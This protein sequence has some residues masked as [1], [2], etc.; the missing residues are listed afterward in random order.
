MCAHSCKKKISNIHSGGL[1]TYV[2]G[3]VKKDPQRFPRAYLRDAEGVCRVADVLSIFYSEAQKADAKAFSTLMQHIKEIDEDKFTVVMVQVENEVGLLG[4]SRDRGIAANGRFESPVPREVLD[5]LSHQNWDYLNGSI[6]KNLEV[7]YSSTSADN[8]SWDS[9]FGSG[10]HAD[11]IFMAYHYALYLEKVASAGKSSY[12]IP[13]YTNVWQNYAGEDGENDFPVIVGGGGLPGDYPSGGAVPHVL[14]I[15][16]SVAPSLDFVAPDIYLNDYSK[17]CAKYRHRNQPLF[18]PEQRRDEYGARRMWV[19]Y[20]SFQALGVS[21]FG[22]DT[23]NPD[24]NPFKK[25]YGLL[26]K[27]SS[28][29]LQ[30][31]CSPDS[32]IG[33]FFDELMPDGHDP[34]PSVTKTFGDWHLIIERS[35]VFGKPGPGF[36]MII[37]LGAAKFLLIGEGF[38]VRFSSTNPDSVFTGILSFTEKKVIDES[39]GAMQTLRRLN[40]DET[41]SGK[42]AIM[43]AEEPD[44]GSFPICVTVPAGTRIAECEVYQLSDPVTCLSCDHRS[45]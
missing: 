45:L 39:T 26:A 36:G 20:G 31:Q 1:S 42:M 6:K 18:V 21:P 12:D 13:L 29:V 30:A 7:F 23:V 33:F 16:L 28:H 15:W 10:P 14:D 11:E 9:V 4:D 44:Y 32:S 19:A 24:S 25:H 17:S 37:H 5:M 41:R 35:F 38:H 27:V 3:W 2:P 8:L 22:I 43:P 40:G 34:S